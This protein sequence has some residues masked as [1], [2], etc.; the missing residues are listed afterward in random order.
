MEIDLYRHIGDPT[1]VANMPH[2]IKIGGYFLGLAPCILKESPSAHFQFQNYGYVH[3]FGL[4]IADTE[5]SEFAGWIN[6]NDSNMIHSH[7][8]IAAARGNPPQFVAWPFCIPR[9]SSDQW[10]D[11]N[12]RA[13]LSAKV[14]S[15]AEQL[16][17]MNI[18]DQT[19]REFEINMPLS[20]TGNLE[21]LTFELADIYINNYSG[22]IIYNDGQFLLNRRW[23]SSGQ[24]PNST[25]W[26]LCYSSF[27]GS[28]DSERRINQ[29]IDEK[30]MEVKKEMWGKKK[31]P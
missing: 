23:I 14:N 3:S 25:T 17:G 22:R 5:S 7:R 20:G 21:L 11:G 31:W 10:I 28:P 26:P 2:L 1:I 12:V 30:V 27:T 6:Y 29:S 15:I 18:K 9:F 19:K 4:E 24:P 8:W 13:F 16:K